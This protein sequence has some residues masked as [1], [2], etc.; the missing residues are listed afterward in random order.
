MRV[1]VVG[2]GGREHAIAWKLSQSCLVDKIFIAP[3]NGGTRLHGE[4]V[5]IKDSDIDKLAEF[6]QENNIDLTIVGPEASLV[7]GIVD[8]FQEKGLK[9]FGPSK[10][11]A[12]LE[13]S[14]VFAK[15]FMEKY[16]IPTAD[17]SIVTSKEEAEEKTKKRNYPYVI[18]VDGL[19][20]GKGAYVVFSEDDKK[21]AFKEIWE[22][23]KFGKSAN[24]VIIEDFLDGE[25]LSVF[26]LTDGENY[27]LLPS[28]QDHKR[29]FDND[30][31]PN[32]GGM[33]AYSPSPLATGELLQKIEKMV[34]QPTLKGMKEIGHPYKGVLYCGLMIA[35]DKPYVLEFNCRFGDPEAQVIIP[36]IKTDFA[37]LLLKV[38]EGKLNEIDFELTEQY[39]VCVVMASGGYPGSYKKGIRIEGLPAPESLAYGVVFHAGTKF[40]NGEYFTSGGRVLGVTCWDETL[41]GAVD[42]AYKVIQTIHFDGAHF[43]KDIARKGLKRLGVL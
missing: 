37:E 17:F 30:Q 22:E 9:I 23:N 13:G 18:K 25:E 11:A 32:T 16:N 4:N 28:A 19:A 10:E 36:P 8:T 27:I 15:K 29:V 2:G 24:R 42:R 14:K 34:I 38:V 3:G 35:D 43:R 20:A 26:A 33:G 40:E 7:E 12:K 39:T 5:P 41:K 6:A 31:G 21:K 1:L